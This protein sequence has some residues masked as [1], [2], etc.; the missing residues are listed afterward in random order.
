VFTEIDQTISAGLG[1]SG[2][3]WKR[4]GDT[5]GLAFVASGLSKEHRDYLSA[6]GKG[7]MLGDGALNYTWEKMLECYYSAQFIPDRLW[8]SGTYQLLM[9]PG[10]NADRSGPVHIFSLRLHWAV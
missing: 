5:A 10:Y 9:D 2:S 1:A 6:G 7:F 3:K 4:K 8:I